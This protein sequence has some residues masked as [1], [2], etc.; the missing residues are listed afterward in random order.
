L[1]L[2]WPW[3]KLVKPL[4]DGDDALADEFRSIV[5]GARNVSL[6]P[7]SL[8]HAERAADLRARFGLRTPDAIHIATAFED[9]CTHIITN[10][11]V[12][13][14]VAGIVVV[15]LDEVLASP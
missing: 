10:D 6:V 7:V 2:S 3:P 1:S 15:V 14:R 12:W 5:V 8:N 9:G 4:R 13:K 11:D